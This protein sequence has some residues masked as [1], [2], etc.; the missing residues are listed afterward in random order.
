MA[1]TKIDIETARAAQV[2]EDLALRE[3]LEGLRGEVGTLSRL[4]REAQEVYRERKAELE[5]LG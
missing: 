3:R 4:E 2:S 1:K 5:S